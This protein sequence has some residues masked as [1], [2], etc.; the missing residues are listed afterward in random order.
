MNGAPRRRAAR[1]IAAVVMA[2]LG[3]LTACSDDPPAAN[4]TV[5]LADVSQSANKGELVDSATSEFYSAVKSAS[6]PATVTLYA[7]N[8]QVGSE[9]C[10][11]LVATVK[12]DRNST[13]VDDEKTK[14]VS[15]APA[16]V[17][18][19]YSCVDE[20]MRAPGTDI[21][22]GI[23]EAS[24]LLKGVSGTRTIELVSD[25]CNNSYDTDLCGIHVVDASWRDARIKALPDSMKPDL[26]G[27]TL[28]VSG[29]AKNAD[30]NSAQVQG[31]KA[32]FSEYAE[33]THAEYTAN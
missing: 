11:P 20:T 33:V 4:A 2:A 15:Q 18:K 8:T 14:L 3:G 17:K 28:N 27:I 23:A 1:V 24:N 32:F 5:V 25:G 26:S 12:W 6:A 13:N 31:L 29:L 10:R 21:F 19:Y 16:A 22:G 9:D 30:L 7:F